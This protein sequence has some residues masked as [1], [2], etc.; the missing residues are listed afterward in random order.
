MQLVHIALRRC[1]TCG[2]GTRRQRCLAILRGAPDLA[3]GRCPLRCS[4]HG[5]H[6]G[7]VLIGVR[8]HRF[9][10]AS[11]GGNRCPGI[12]VFIA[13]DGLWGVQAFLQYSGDA[14]A[15]YLF[16]RAVVPNNRQRLQRGFGTPPGV[17]HHSHSAVAHTHHFLHAGAFFNRCGIKAFQ[18]AAKHWAVLDGGIQHARQHQITRINLLAGGF[19]NRVQPG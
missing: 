17:G 9:N 15:R 10:F 2:L 18:L 8:V 19:V 5:F 6:G 3:T 11:A 4:V 12:A 7:V 16:I 13:H 14:L 1:Q